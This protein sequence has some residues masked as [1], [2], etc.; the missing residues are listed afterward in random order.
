[1]FGWSNFGAT[2]GGVHGTCT[3]VQHKL[4]HG[5]FER[6]R[7][8]MPHSGAQ[9]ASPQIPQ[10]TGPGDLRTTVD[11][12]QLGAWPRWGS[13]SVRFGGGGR[14]CHARCDDAM[15][16][17]AGTRSPARRAE[18]RTGDPGHCWAF[19]ADACERSVKRRERREGGVQACRASRL[20]FVHPASDDGVPAHAPLFAFRAAADLGSWVPLPWPCLLP[21]LNFLRKARVDA[22]S[23][24]SEFSS[25]KS[26]LFRRL[27]AGLAPWKPGSYP[28]TANFPKPAYS[29]TPSTTT[30]FDGYMHHIPM[31]WQ[32][33]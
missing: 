17:C 21:A 30:L 28:A 27:D 15:A 11:Q 12:V 9:R 19:L 22:L 29:V 1:M 31:L 32:H 16:A 26:A 3:P 8:A 10:A 33:N 13:F 20:G 23:T 14:W 6:W 2:R 18:G 7:P 5:G 25:S 4:E 24:L